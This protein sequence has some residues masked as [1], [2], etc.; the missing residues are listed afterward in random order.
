M[1]LLAAGVLLVATTVT[2][3]ES[4]T[5]LVEADQCYRRREDV[6]QV[7]RAIDL[8]QQVLNEDPNAFEAAWR[9]SRAYWYEG[10][11]APKK[12]R[13]D[14]FRKGVE[15]A[16][17]AVGV[18]PGRC[19]GHF[20]LGL[21]YAMLAENSGMFKALGLVNDVKQEMKSAIAIDDKCVCGG[22][23]RVLGRLYAKI[24]WFKGGSKSKS[25]EYLKKSIEY[26]PEDTQSRIFL[27][28]TY[29]DQGRKHEA[30]EQLRLVLQMEG[31][32]DWIPETKEN[33]IE[34]EKMLSKLEKEK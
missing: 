5:L 17:K 21:N 14:I 10:N 15:V 33:K 29:L 19:E 2:A 11:H 18:S 3:Q 30:I 7:K 16:G 27:A 31:L 22:P 25:V 6:S 12:E 23:Q 1:R 34:A 24:P 4:T 13:A 32:P 28:Q 9:L 26:C 8:Y 20:W